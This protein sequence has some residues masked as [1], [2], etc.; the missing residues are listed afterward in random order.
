MSKEIVSTTNGFHKGVGQVLG[1]DGAVR[2]DRPDVQDLVG[3]R[4]S[5]KIEIRNVGHFSVT[6]GLGVVQN[7]EET[8]GK[9][10]N[11]SIL[12]FP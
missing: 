5:L 8:A 9:C 11:G 10:I 4:V 2:Q 1:K 12:A 3:R 6:I 7:N